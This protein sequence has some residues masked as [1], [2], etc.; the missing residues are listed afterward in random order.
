MKRPSKNQLKGL[1]YT[2]F[3]KSANIA[4]L[5]GTFGISHSRTYWVKL[6]PYNK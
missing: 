1:K 6:V 5:K 4:G 2:I 3:Q